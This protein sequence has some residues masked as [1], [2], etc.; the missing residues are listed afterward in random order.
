M[1]KIGI[2][3]A[4]VEEM[5]ILLN[6]LED[7][8]TQTIG[9]R[10]YNCGNLW[11]N[12]VVLVFSRWGK[13]AASSTTTTLIT[14]FKVDEIIFTGVA[15]A[16]DSNINI[17]DVIVA[18]HLF[19]HDFDASP[20]LLKHVLPLI[21]KKEIE[22][23]PIIKLGLFEAGSA[24]LE[25][26]IKGS[27]SEEYLKEYNITEP[28]ILIGNIAS[29]DQF[30]KDSNKRDEIKS[31]LENVLAVEMEGAAVAQVCFEFDIPLGVIRTISDDANDNAVHDFPKFVNHIASQY[32]FFILKNY[33]SN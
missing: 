3:S 12:D 29:G 31:S 33:L 23:N 17:G 28:K 21:M 7:K 20:F 2:M 6:Y 9:K 19:Q 30:I 10:E 22:T 8:N 5:D 26:Q 13:V 18:E 4:M 1:K 27:I 14:E 32:S 11:G 16:L 25:T 24:F 15:G